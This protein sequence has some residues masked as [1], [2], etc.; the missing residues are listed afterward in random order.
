MKNNFMIECSQDSNSRKI[1]WP[2][3][4]LGYLGE[5]CKNLTLNSRFFSLTINNSKLL[6][7]I[8]IFPQ[9]IPRVGFFEELVSLESSQFNE[10]FNKL[11][12]NFKYLTMQKNIKKNVLLNYLKILLR[13]GCA[14]YVAHFPLQNKIDCQIQYEIK[15]LQICARIEISLADNNQP[16]LAELTE[17]IEHILL[18][19]NISQLFKI[20]VLNGCIPIL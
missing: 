18:S 1:N 8:L 13:Y 19:K 11:L 20:L 4:S 10:N 9:R 14:E 12:T 15:F 16:D 5:S 6:N 3:I 17:F 2:H 7:S